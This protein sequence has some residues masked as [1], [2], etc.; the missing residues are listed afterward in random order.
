[1]PVSDLVWPASITIDLPVLF[2]HASM[3]ACQ[4]WSDIGMP[5]NLSFPIEAVSKVPDCCYQLVFAAAFL[6]KPTLEGVEG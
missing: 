5:E 2:L 4:Y 6:A 1:M 3:P